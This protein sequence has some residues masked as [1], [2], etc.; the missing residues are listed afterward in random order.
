MANRVAFA[1][2]DY[3]RWLSPTAL[4]AAPD[5]GTLYIACA[6][7]DRVLFFDPGTRKVV[8][9]V[10]TSRSPSGLALSADGKTLFVTGAKPESQVCIVDVAQA[11]VVGK[12]SAGHTAMAPVLSP[13]GKTLYVCN[14]FNDDV[15]VFDVATRTERCR[16][17]VRR[18]PTAAAVTPD[19][20]HLL[21]ANHLP[22]GRADVDHVAATVSVIDTAGRQVVADLRLPSGSGSLNDLRISP[23]GRYAVVTHGLA[24]FHLP[25]TQLDR[26]WMYT[27]A[28][29]IIGLDR[30]EVVNT[31]LLDNVDRGAANSWGVAWSADGKMLVVAH[32]GTHE[33]SVIDFSGVLEKLA[34]LSS[35]RAVSPGTPAPYSSSASRV[36][37][38]VPNDLAFLVGLR[39]RRRLPDGD[40]GPRAVA[41]VGRTAYAADYFSDTLTVIE[42]DG[43][44]PKAESIPLGPKP[45]MTAAREGELYFH[46]A[47]ICF[48]GWQSCSSCHPGD[49]RVDALNWDLLNDGIGNPKNNKSLLLAYK[50]PPSMS[51]SVRE[52]A[53][54]AVRA[55]IRHVLFTVQPAEVAGAMDAYLQGLQPVPSPR[56]TKGRFSPAAKRGEK[57]FNSKEA[58]C[59]QCHPWPLLTDLQSYD[60]GTASRFDRDTSSFDTPTLIEIWRTAPYLHDGSAAT[61]RDV[62]TTANRG[63]Q[64]GKTSHL[65][66]EQLNDLIE[67][68]LSL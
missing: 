36:P 35:P 1:A 29:T 13:D 53:A 49:A 10:A 9:S 22:V 33:V 14:R 52:D 38:D 42:L 4:I 67:F 59:T 48:Q 16:I 23:D 34:G 68:L 37:S 6:T 27:N 65:T 3:A 56:L 66:A 61:I 43:T 63:D 5:G 58:G 51:L 64:H 60:V 40:L 26:G 8:K 32:A 7:G 21:V 50:T 2:D 20:R 62:L 18:E 54:A 45:Q 19:G 46:D 25:T 15:S 24:R 55:G 47:R 41:V 12:F 11:Q 39:E 30:M 44:H 57:L 31:V 17:P 28:K